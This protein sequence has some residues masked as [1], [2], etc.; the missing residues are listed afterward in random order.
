MLFQTVLDDNLFNSFTSLVTTFDKM[1][2]IRDLVKFYPNAQNFMAMLT[3]STVGKIMPDF[4]DEYGENKKIDV[5]LSPSHSLFLDGF[6]ESKMT[7][8]YVDKN[9]NWKIQLNVP[10]QINIE[11]L[12]S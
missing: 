3:T 5:V 4:V 10:L 1:F 12:P 9:G 8:V 11:T 7:G 2:S 6:P